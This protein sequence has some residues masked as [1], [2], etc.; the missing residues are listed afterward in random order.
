LVAILACEDMTSEGTRNLLPRF[1]TILRGRDSKASA[2]RSLLVST[3]AVGHCVYSGEM[4]WVERGTMVDEYSTHDSISSVVMGP[5]HNG[6]DGRI[7]SL[8]VSPIA[9]PFP[10]WL[11]VN[12]GFDST[13]GNYS[14]HRGCHERVDSSPAAVFHNVGL[15]SR[16]GDRLLPLEAQ[17][18]VSFQ[19]RQ[20][21]RSFEVRSCSMDC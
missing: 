21:P 15:R 7:V 3:A 13:A 17:R 14:I 1:P 6:H 18:N 19:A 12:Q 10:A 9:L 20:R 2:S 16:R 5:L 11:S 8:L 4:R